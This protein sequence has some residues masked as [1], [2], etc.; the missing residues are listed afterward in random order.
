MKKSSKPSIASFLK[1]VGLTFKNRLVHF[2]FFTMCTSHLV[3]LTSAMIFI[4][5]FELIVVTVKYLCKLLLY[6]TLSIS[7]YR[8]RFVLDISICELFSISDHFLQFPFSP[9][10]VKKWQKFVKS[11]NVPSLLVIDNL[12]PS[13]F[14]C[15]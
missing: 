12:N 5:K 9:P 10:S 3:I 1:D 8:R 2:L 15:Q 6:L 14:P 7:L 11:Q 4:F 13:F